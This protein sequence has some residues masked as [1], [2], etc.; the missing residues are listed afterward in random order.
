MSSDESKKSQNGEEL[1]FLEEYPKF[2]ETRS[3]ILR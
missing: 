1:I 2:L 3:F